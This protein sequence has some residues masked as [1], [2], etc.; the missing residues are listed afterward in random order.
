M[1]KY[2]NHNKH[3]QIETTVPVRS[4]DGRGYFPAGVKANAVID[5]RSESALC[6]VGSTLVLL[7]K[8][9]YQELTDAPFREV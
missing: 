9:D 7:Q 6:R 4:E 3:A 5:V 2:K 1:G 8:E